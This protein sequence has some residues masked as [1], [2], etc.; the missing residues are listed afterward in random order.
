MDPMSAPE[1]AAVAIFGTAA[2][3]RCRM[4]ILSC[5]VLVIRPLLRMS[6]AVSSSSLVSRLGFA[7]LLVLV[8]ILHLDQGSVSQR[9]SNLRFARL[10]KD[11]RD[12]PQGEQFAIADI[13]SLVLG[14]A[15]EI[16]RSIST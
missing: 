16:N 6:S 8:V 3:P 13:L 2:R 10:E 15:E 12:L 11:R 1:S 7:L 4:V 5:T 9:P 14:E